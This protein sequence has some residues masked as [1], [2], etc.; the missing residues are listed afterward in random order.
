MEMC[1]KCERVGEISNTW[2]KNI[3]RMGTNLT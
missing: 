1:L 2:G 3:N